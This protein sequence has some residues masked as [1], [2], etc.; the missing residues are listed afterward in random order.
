MSNPLQHYVPPM[1]RC[2]QGHAEHRRIRR[3][4][5]AWRPAVPRSG[6]GQRG[7]YRFGRVGYDGEQGTGRPPR[8]S[9]ALFPISN[10]LDGNAK[11][12]GKFQLRQA[13]AATKIANRRRSLLLRSSNGRLCRGDRVERR[14]RGKHGGDQRKLPPVSQLDNPSVRFQPQALHFDPISVAVGN[15]ISRPRMNTPSSVLRP[16]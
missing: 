9:F 6:F 14:R 3:Y 4:A 1:R 10:G 11:P 16:D 8:H 7:K 13:G 12:I 5:A 2:Q 15:Q